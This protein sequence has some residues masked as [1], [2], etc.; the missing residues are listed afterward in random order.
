MVG[1]LLPAAVDAAE[2]TS[3]GQCPECVCQK[4]TQLSAT[5]EVVRIMAGL[6]RNR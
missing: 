2:K 1:Q 5:E 4:R 3:R 6:Q